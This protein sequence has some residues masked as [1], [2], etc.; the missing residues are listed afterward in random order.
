MN[1]PGMGGT[2]TEGDVQA[3]GAEVEE[4]QEEQD[5]EGLSPE[6]E[7]AE[8]KP[9]PKKDADEGRAADLERQL[10]E[11]NEIIKTILASPERVRAFKEWAAKDSGQ[12]GS[13]SAELSAHA[14]AMR[15]KWFSHPQA[16]ASGEAIEEWLAPY[17]QRI[18]DL[19]TQ[20]RGVGQKAELAHQ[21]TSEGGF[22]KTLVSNGVSPKEQGSPEWK[23]HEASEMRDRTFQSLRAKN[24]EFAARHL[25]AS[26]VAKRATTNG[27]V[28]QNRHVA[29]LKAGRLHNAPTTGNGSQKVIVID[30]TQPGWDRKAFEIRAKNPNAKIAYKSDQK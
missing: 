14:K 29:D 30:D 10:S 1:D 16:A 17:A 27:N 6:G 7:A 25:A 9:A 12:G 19:E 28:A 23:A 26:W 3:D 13:E 5:P 24:P 8:E 22:R 20:L 15:E 11:Q 2:S 18:A 4:T 21:F